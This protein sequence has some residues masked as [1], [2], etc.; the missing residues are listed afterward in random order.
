MINMLPHERKKMHKSV[1][2]KHE[3]F[4][5]KSEPLQNKG[6]KILKP[7][8]LTRR[9]V[10]AILDQASK[11]KNPSKMLLGFK[12]NAAELYSRGIYLKDIISILPLDDLYKL[13]FDFESVAQ[14]SLKL[15]NNKNI[16][17][18]I[19]FGTRYKKLD[20]AI[21]A[22]LAQKIK[23]EEIIQ[24]M[25]KNNVSLYETI[26]AVKNK[27]KLHVLVKSLLELKKVK[28]YDIFS[29]L[30]FNNYDLI[31]I[32]KELAS[33]NVPLENLV[34]VMKNIDIDA[35]TISKTLLSVSESPS[36]IAKVMLYSKYSVFETTRSL[37]RAGVSPVL[38]AK[39]MLSSKVKESKLAEIFIKLGIDAYS[40]T[41][42]LSEAG[43]NIDNIALGL[44]NA[45]VDKDT[46]RDIFSNK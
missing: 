39:A 23:L 22:L 38:V 14:L 4:K 43:A 5:K 12:L 45:D 29:N 18:V 30:Y 35:E 21:S 1:R 27:V 3:E 9:D 32:T 8:E 34:D 13:G 42:Y 40:T 7:E 17:D 20:K 6:L 2:L 46:I 41:R 25:L 36:T 24:S 16:N 19:S 10:I 15:N 44:L 26:G 11:L 28:V 37:L 33:F 31:E